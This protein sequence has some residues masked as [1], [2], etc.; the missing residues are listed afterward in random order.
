[1]ELPDWRLGGDSCCGSIRR[2]RAAGSL[3]AAEDGEARLKKRLRVGCD[4]GESRCAELVLVRRRHCAAL[5]VPSIYGS[6]SRATMGLIFLALALPLHGAVRLA[7]R[8]AVRWPAARSTICMQTSGDVDS[9]K[10]TPLG[11]L[12][13]KLSIGERIGQGTKN[14]WVN[15]AYWNRQF[16]T[17]SHIA[18]NIPNGSNVLELGKDAK[19]LYYVTQPKAMTLIVPPSNL[20][21]REGPIREAAAKL[22]VPFS[23]Y[24]EKPLDT[25]PLTPGSFDAAIIFDMLDGAPQQASERPR[26]PCRPGLSAGRQLHVRIE[27]GDLGRRTSLDCTMPRVCWAS[28]RVGASC[29]GAPPDIAH[30]CCCVCAGILWS[31]LV[32]LQ[33]AAEGWPP[34]LLGTRDR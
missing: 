1:M 9:A 3:T 26:P 27:P 6:R 12:A 20:V 24:T 28:G 18:N 10:G 11:E 29:G 33:R 17:A 34:D 15:P 32:A 21:V 14:S 8:Q 23:L 4:M 5:P 22:N 16:V 7:P 30:L 19:N 25:I 31:D 2:F 13:E